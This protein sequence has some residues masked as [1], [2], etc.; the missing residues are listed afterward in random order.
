M[1]DTKHI[2]QDF[3]SVALNMSQ[4]WDFGSLWVPRW[5]KISNMFMWHMKSTKMTS[6]TEC[7]YFLSWSQTGDLRVRSRVNYHL[8]SVTMS[9]SKIFI[10]NFVCVLTNERYK[11]IRWDFY[12][13]AWVM[14]QGWDFGSLGVPRWSIFFSNMV[15][16]HI[17]STRMTS[18]T[19][20]K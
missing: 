1:K 15:M 11:H 17:K 10:P 16:W 3:Y 18:R 4:G 14:S 7:K 2:R 19:E 20:C 6:R 9:I 8:I 13:V 5:S 12:S